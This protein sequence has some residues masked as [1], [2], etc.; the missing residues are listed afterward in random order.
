MKRWWQ[1]A[2]AGWSAVVVTILIFLVV[3][4]VPA[5]PHGHAVHTPGALQLTVQSYPMT[6]AR[7][8]SIR[9]EADES[10]DTVECD[11][12]RNS[13]LNP[14]GS[15]DPKDP[16]WHLFPTAS[17]APHTLYLVWNGCPIA[18]GA[19]LNFEYL[20][21]QR[22]VL[23]HCYQATPFVYFPE[24]FEGIAPMPLPAL[25]AI[26]DGAFGAGPLKIHE[27]DR[28]EHWV[29]DQTVSEFQLTAAN[30]G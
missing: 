27:D 17:Q 7:D 18:P 19:G 16:G 26:P 15:C 8:I 3:F 6:P 10:L 21:A 9:A 28:Q 24:R 29:G 11:A 25:Y 2:W 4:V 5:P 14:S 20:P 23:V 1:R 30:I 12:S 22:A 13:Y